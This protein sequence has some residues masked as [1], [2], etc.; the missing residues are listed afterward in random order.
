MCSFLVFVLARLPSSNTS[1]SRGGFSL[2]WHCGFVRVAF[3]AVSYP[4]AR[5]DARTRTRTELASSNFPCQ[6]LVLSLKSLPL[7]PTK[8]TNRSAALPFPQRAI[9][10][11]LFSSQGHLHTKSA[12]AMRATGMASLYDP[13]SFAQETQELED[14]PARKSEEEAALHAV[15]ISLLNNLSGKR[16]AEPF[17]Y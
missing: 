9:K 4:D 15:H 17:A 12:L 1:F 7:A 8:T 11:H 10:P 6:H 13:K 5:T 3:C 2:R 16:R 14:T